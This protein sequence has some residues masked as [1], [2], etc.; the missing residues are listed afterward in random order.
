MVTILMRQESSFMFYTWLDQTPVGRLLIAGTESGLKYVSF[1]A[2]HFSSPE[3]TPETHWEPNARALREPVK[4]LTAYFAGR[5]RQFDVPLDAEGT[6]FQK[7]VWNALLTVPFGQT[8]SYGEIARRIGNPGA[9]R[10]VGLANGRNPIA[11]IVPCHRIIGINGRLVG[12]GGGLPYKKALLNLEGA[13]L[14]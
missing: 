5:L 4:Q 1:S 12:Y 10:A 7:S 3:V 6:C 14:S 9:S 2:A 11:I 13:M 8:A